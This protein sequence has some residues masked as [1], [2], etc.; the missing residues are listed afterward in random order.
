MK[1]V[2]QDANPRGGERKCHRVSKPH[3]TVR[4]SNE[5]SDKTNAST[6]V[7]SALFVVKAVWHD[8]RGQYSF[9]RRQV[10]AQKSKGPTVLVVEDNLEAQELLRANLEDAGYEVVVAGNGRDALA[11]LADQRVPS[12]LIVD[13]VMPVMGGMELLDV[14]RSYR[15]LAAIPVLV[16]SGFELPAGAQG[17]RVRYLRKP[18]RKAELLASVSELAPIATS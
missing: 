4:T 14:V 7:H 16:V 15:R 10:M 17:P 12:L 11:A 2:I 3:V 18:V 9:G 5:S 13:L 1:L 6:R 8:H